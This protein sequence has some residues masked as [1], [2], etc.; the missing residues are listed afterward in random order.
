MKRTRKDKPGYIGN[1]RVNIEYSDKEID[2]RSIAKV[3]AVEYIKQR[4]KDESNQKNVAGDK[5]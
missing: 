4:D 3:I 5:L 1:R 2:W